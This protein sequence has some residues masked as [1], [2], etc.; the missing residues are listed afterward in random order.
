MKNRDATAQ[1]RGITVLNF[2]S[3]PISTCAMWPSLIGSQHPHPSQ[4]CCQDKRKELTF[5]A[6]K[7]T[8]KGILENLHLQSPMFKDFQGVLLEKL[9]YLAWS[10]A[11]D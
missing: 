10:F 2:Q 9:I 4:C 6:L 1:W 11:L 5:V 8:F 7:N 3:P